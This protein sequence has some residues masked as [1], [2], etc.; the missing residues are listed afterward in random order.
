LHVFVAKKNATLVNTLG[1]NSV[2]Q[3]NVTM[4]ML[5]RSRI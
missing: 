5:D 1:Q 4:N 3:R 2:F